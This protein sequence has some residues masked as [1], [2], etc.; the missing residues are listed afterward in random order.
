MK[1]GFICSVVTVVP[2]AVWFAERLICMS[3]VPYGYLTHACAD[4]LLV[5]L[6][7]LLLLEM[8]M[9]FAV[10]LFKCVGFRV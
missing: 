3:A 1:C 6:L 8:F 9:F 4:M 5:L 7:L 2:K 10:L